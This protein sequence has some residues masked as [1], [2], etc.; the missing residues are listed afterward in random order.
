MA[1]DAGATFGGAGDG[2]KSEATTKR[3][4]SLVERE[5]LPFADAV[6][7]YGVQMNP[8]CLAP[9]TA[10]FP[11]TLP[12]TAL[13]RAFNYVLYHIVEPLLLAPQDEV[14]VAANAGAQAK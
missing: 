5:G 8:T 14:N 9:R 6:L 12:R 2:A 10:R 7:T 11:R 3:D 4:R 1:S 13:G